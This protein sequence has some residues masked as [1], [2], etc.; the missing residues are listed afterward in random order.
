MA[1]GVHLTAVAHSVA[2]AARHAMS[3]RGGRRTLR[4]TEARSLLAAQS[5]V[6]SAAAGNRSSGCQLSNWHL[7]RSRQYHTDAPGN[8]TIQFSTADAISAHFSDSGHALTC[9]CAL[10]VCVHSGRHH[11]LLALKALS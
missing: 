4:V 9:M 1:A 8:Q 7:S 10:H 6:A 5:C 3:S 11:R 2:R